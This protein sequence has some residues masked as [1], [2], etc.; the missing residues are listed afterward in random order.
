MKKSTPNLSSSVQSIFKQYGGADM[1]LPQYA[2]LVAAYGALIAGLIAL[3]GKSGSARKI[4]FGQLVWLGISTHKLS[5]LVSKDRVTSPFRAP[6][7]TF[8]KSDGA[9]EVEEEARGSGMQRAIGDLVT[10]PFCVSPWVALAL[11]AGWLLL[12]RATRIVCGIL[13]SV[14]LAHFL[15]HGYVALENRKEPG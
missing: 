9:G 15:H 7:A 11:M 12:P 10:C 8:V 3:E 4:G 2:A 1:P 5:R 6:F 13:T 14:A